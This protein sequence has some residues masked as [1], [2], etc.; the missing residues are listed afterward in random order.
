MHFPSVMFSV[1]PTDFVPQQAQGSP[2]PRPPALGQ[3]SPFLGPLQDEPD[4]LVSLE[5]PS[6][7]APPPQCPHPRLGSVTREYSSKSNNSTKSTC[8]AAAIT[9]FY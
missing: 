2:L 6:P 9:Y 4:L 1:P 7:G 5:W 3:V 8:L